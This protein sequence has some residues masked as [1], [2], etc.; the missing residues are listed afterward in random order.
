VGRRLRDHHDPHFRGS[1]MGD[2]RS[3]AEPPIV[4]I[5]VGEIAFS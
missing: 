5:D 4:S 2:G 3:L 1:V